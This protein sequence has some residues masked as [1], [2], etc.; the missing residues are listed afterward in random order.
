M[1]GII[2]AHA[3]V[4]TDEVFMSLLWGFPNRKITVGVESKTPVWVDPKLASIANIPPERNEIGTAEQRQ[5]R[6]D[7][8]FL[9]CGGIFLVELLHIPKAIPVDHEPT[10]GQLTSGQ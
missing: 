1:R 10:P 2:K 8:G 5:A 7:K 9:R 3:R 6:L 4:G